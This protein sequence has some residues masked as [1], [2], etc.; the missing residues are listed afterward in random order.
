MDFPAQENCP[1]CKIV[2]RKSPAAV[3]LENKKVLAIMDLYPAAPGHVL[4]LP[5]QHI[6]NI[7]V[8]LEETGAGI[9]AAAVTISRAIHRQLKPAGINLVQANGAIAGQTI[10]HF[11]LHI[12]PRYIDDT[13]EI[14]FGHGVV[15]A[16][17]RELEQT[18]SMIRNA[19]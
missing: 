1:F 5:R 9:M 13:V 15:P 19:L 18:A 17:I 12:V 14:K 11:H 16:D 2:Q 3:V 8:M 10:N 4:V 7:Y 6:E